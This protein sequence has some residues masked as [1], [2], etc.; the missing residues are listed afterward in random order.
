MDIRKSIKIGI[1]ALCL[2]VGLSPAM[3]GLA[4][5]DGIDQPAEAQAVDEAV[6]PDEETSPAD[7]EEAQTESQ[8]SLDEGEGETAEEAVPEATPEADEPAAIAD[9]DAAPQENAEEDEADAPILGAPLG[10]PQ[11]GAI[12]VSGTIKASDFA[13]G[14]ELILD[15]ATTL[16]MDVPRTFKSIGTDPSAP[17][18]VFYDLKVTGSNPFV[19]DNP[20]GDGVRA[21]SISVEGDVRVSVK[22]I[23]LF[24]REGGITI[25]GSIQGDTGVH[26]ASAPNGG[27]ITVKGDANLTAGESGLYCSNGISVGGN[28]TSD[29]RVAALYCWGGGV[30][31]KG[32]CDFTG[33]FGAYCQGD[34][35]LGSNVTGKPSVAVVYTWSGAV[36]IDGNF[37]SSSDD[38]SYAIFSQKMITINGNVN[39]TSRDN[40]LF[41]PSGPIYL[42]GDVKITAQ[43]AY[44][45]FCYEGLDI[46]GNVDVAGGAYGILVPSGSSKVT[47]TGDTIKATST[48]NNG[49]GIAMAVGVPVEINGD[50]ELS[51]VNYG[52]D[53]WGPSVAINGN[54][55]ATSLASDS[56]AVYCSSGPLTVTGDLEATAEQGLAV[57]TIHGVEVGGN[58]TAISDENHDALYVP[59]GSVIV[60]GDLTA[61]GC[62]GAYAQGPI[63]VK[64]DTTITASVKGIDCY[65]GDVDLYG[66]VDITGGPY[67]IYAS[68][69]SGTLAF[70]G[71]TVNVR[72]TGDYANAAIF[73]VGTIELDGMITATGGK[74]GILMPAGSGKTVA[75][76]G[77]IEATGIELAIASATAIVINDPLEIIDPENGEV[78]TGN[79]DGGAF[80]TVVDASGTP[81]KHT[82]IAQAIT[83]SFD[84]NGGTGT[85]DDVQKYYGDTYQLPE[86]GFGVP[87]CKEFDGWDAGAAGESLTLTEDLTLV[88]Q[89][90]DAHNWGEWTVTKEPTATTPGERQR[91]CKN[92]P[93]HVETEEIPATGEVAVTYAFSKG[94]GAKWTKGS[95]S[96]LDFTV[97]RSEADET[98]FSHFTSISV[99]GKVLPSSAYTAASGSLNVT[100]QASYLETLSAG[101]HT[102]T[103]SFDDG[104]ATATFTVDNAARPSAVPTTGDATSLIPAVALGLAG[105]CAIAAS[106]A[107]RA[108][109]RDER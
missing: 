41:C 86:N 73:G 20:D 23:G 84:A 70:H 27:S 101:E 99:D 6:I 24:A 42:T 102:I 92:N 68:S 16:Q 3:Q 54:L 12:R 8:D 98:T 75:K 69:T 60:G 61:Q 37:T 10:A 7:G 30:E 5:A 34:V 32:D 4:F 74:Y 103:A 100:L 18:P 25:G 52:L 39:V 104:S 56:Y 85:M 22:G 50:V 59:V 46:K 49:S 95:K 29:C 14:A 67:G 38:S 51:G 71:G 65:G 35:K 97:N 15:G 36:E 33:Q 87:Q 76:V 11:N 78:G 47:I 62:N 58:A 19:I 79:V 80:S 13:D 106:A 17:A 77:R 72:A 48:I 9:A 93:S 43:K 107:A 109:G 40:G 108:K 94:D 105:A 2:V 57:G 26:C 82:I 28:V 91:V 88:A 89:W 1:I 55:K 31:V 81:M 45:L 44:G 63:V 90:K 83:V 64:G 96:G 53:S 66:D 21:K